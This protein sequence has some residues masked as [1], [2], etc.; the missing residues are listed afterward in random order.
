MKYVG[1][2]YTGTSVTR[3]IF[4]WLG[5]KR[6]GP[7]EYYFEDEKGRL[8][9]FQPYPI[10]PMVKEWSYILRGSSDVTGLKFM[11]YIEALNDAGEL[12]STSPALNGKELIHPQMTAKEGDSALMRLKMYDGNLNSDPNHWPEPYKSAYLS[13]R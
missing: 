4:A 9:T 2:R 8:T 3:M 5:I 13:G 6:K 1:K 7:F 10:S 11:P 12:T